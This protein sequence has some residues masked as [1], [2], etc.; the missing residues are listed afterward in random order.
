MA[1][2]QTREVISR[3][4]EHPLFERLGTAEVQIHRLSETRELHTFENPR[5]DQLYYVTL[6]TQEL[7]S[8]CPATGHPD[9]CSLGI[10]YGPKD[11]CVEMKS[12]KLYVETFR[13]EGH[14][15]EELINLIY[16]NLK[17][18]LDPHYLRVRGDFNTRGGWPATVEVCSDDQSRTTTEGDPAE[19]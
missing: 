5:V 12:L 15:Y 18:V 9:F 14:F 1:S 7:T 6:T 16:S 11:R 19:D 8:L 10:V 3:I 17:E 2:Q 4:G 13:N